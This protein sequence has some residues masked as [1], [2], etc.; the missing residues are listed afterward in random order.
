[1]ESDVADSISDVGL[2]VWSRSSVRAAGC[3][4]RQTQVPAAATKMVPTPCLRGPQQLRIAP[5]QCKRVQELAD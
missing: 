5:L 2:I 1:M 3:V 4:L